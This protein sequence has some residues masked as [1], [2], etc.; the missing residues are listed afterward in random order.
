MKIKVVT[1]EQYKK[2]Y[3]VKIG[4]VAYQRQYVYVGMQ[5][6]NYVVQD[7][8]ESTKKEK[9]QLIRDGVIER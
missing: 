6:Q 3:F 2:G 1:R 8:E 4:A 9:E 5:G 7:P